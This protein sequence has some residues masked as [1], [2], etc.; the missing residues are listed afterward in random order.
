VA[1]QVADWTIKNMQEKDGHFI[2]R[3]YQYGIKSRAAMIHWGQATM[4]A[5]LAHLLSVAG[6]YSARSGENQ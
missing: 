3:I 1:G 5:A 4:F 6:Q 2:F